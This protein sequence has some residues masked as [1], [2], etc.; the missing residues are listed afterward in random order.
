[1][2]LRSSPS[3][4]S[5]CSACLANALWFVEN[6]FRAARPVPLAIAGR[7]GGRRPGGGV[8]YSGSEI[9]FANRSGNLCRQSSGNIFLARNDIPDPSK[10]PRQCPDETARLPRTCLPITVFS[11]ESW[12]QPIVLTRS[13]RPGRVSTDGTGSPHFARQRI[14]AVDGPGERDTTRP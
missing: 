7:A 9:H 2:P 10:R 11:E 5:D 3:R 14:G 4:S 13:N 1:M 6:I 12:V 8:A